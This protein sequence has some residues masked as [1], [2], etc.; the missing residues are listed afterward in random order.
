MGYKERQLTTSE[1]MLQATPKTRN[2]FFLQV[3]LLENKKDNRYEEVATKLDELREGSLFQML[4][5]FLI[6]CLYLKGSK[7]KTRPRYFIY[8]GSQEV[9]G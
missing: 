7:Y 8:C 9:C 4:E 5:C 2:V 3:I 6:F 1:K